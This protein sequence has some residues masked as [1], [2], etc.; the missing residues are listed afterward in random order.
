MHSSD[1]GGVCGVTAATM[2]PTCLRIGR[3]P[4]R[5]RYSIDENDQRHP[6][7]KL[8]HVVD[9][10]TR[11]LGLPRHKSWR[12]RPDYHTPTSAAAN[13]Q[14]TLPALSQLPTLHPDAR[15]PRGIVRQLHG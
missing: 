1:A 4:L 7:C 11:M 15:T 9:I 14:A 8:H 12:S 10:T 5:S 6:Q 2:L 3:A 13:D